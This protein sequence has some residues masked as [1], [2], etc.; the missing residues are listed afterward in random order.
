M[1]I[2]EFLAR[3]LEQS[4]GMLKMHVADFSDADLLA[5][6]VPGANHA[7]WQLG[8]LIASESRTMARCG[9]AMPPLPEGFAQRDAKDN[10]QNDDPAKFATKAE[11][12]ATLATTRAAS[13]AF[14]R[15]ATPAQL[16]A[17]SPMAQ[18]W[19]TVG[20]LLASWP[21]HD[22]MHIGQ[23]QVLRRKLAKPLLF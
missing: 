19:P 4:L 10:T 11:L 8:H 2:N 21:T 3:G 22:A 9:A 5:R 17:P 18:V 6:P 20:D 7:N 23:I 16:D 1:T 14:A 13:V 12:L 15:S